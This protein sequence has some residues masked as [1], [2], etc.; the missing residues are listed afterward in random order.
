MAIYTLERGLILRRGDAH[1]QVHRVVDDRHVQLEHA[2]TGKIRTETIARLT[3]DITAGKA[4]VIRDA[5]ARNDASTPA[6]GHK[7]VCA[8]SIPERYQ[9][10]YAR[11]HDYLRHM[12]RRG[13]SKGQRSRIAEAIVHV[14]ASIQDN[15]P[16]STSTVMRWM[17]VF[18]SNAD[19]PSCLISGHVRRRRQ[20]RIPPE[21]RKIIEKVL[22]R[23]YFRKNGSSLRQAHD[24]VIQ[25]LNEEAEAGRLSSAFADVSLSTVRRI[26]Y[27]VPPFDRDRLRLGTA[28]ARH[29]WRSSRPG[30]YATRPLERV[31]M[32]H[33]LL[34]IWVIDDRWGIPLGRPTITFLVCGYSS[35]IL[36]FYISFEGETLARTLQ[37]IKIAIQPKD[38]ITTAAKLS[39]RWHAMG[40]WETLVVDNALSVHSDRL[41]LIMNE[42][43]SDLEYCPVRMPWFKPTVERSLGELTR[44]LPAHGRPQKPGRQPDPIDPS[45]TA[46][47]TFSDLCHGI[48]QWVV[49]VHPF[50]INQRKMSRPVDL[51]LEGLNDCPAPAFVDNYLSLD[52]LAGPRKTVAVR[53]DGVVHEWLTYT[54]DELAQMRRE[55]GTNFRATMTYNPYDLGSIFV[56]HPHTRAWVSVQAKDQEYATGLSSTQHRLIRAAAKQRLTLANA[57]DLLRKARLELQ[58]GWLTAFASGKRIKRAP[59]DFSLFQQV[60]A[61]SIAPSSSPNQP[62]KLPEKFVSD[63]EFVEL[64]RP[65]PSF[66]TFVGDAK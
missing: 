56:Q 50:E 43:C 44:Q 60:S 39:N 21:F 12:R 23:Y 1:W 28:E 2:E 11:A 17:R 52:V 61:I 53:H 19:N 34:D 25:T 47:I 35:Y 20:Q 22:T 6:A 64:K 10:A 31:E 27:E 57:P 48:L 4:E 29:K 62:P 9:H 7:L 32:D 14:A 38:A 30:I 18:E 63:E 40:L 15:R 24:R 26:A 65:I 8:A 51:F 37:S 16:P 3:A 49:D 45:V 54:G 33:T 5:D 55:M 46:C 42:L 66:E 13:I 58:D 41:R 36:G 59:R